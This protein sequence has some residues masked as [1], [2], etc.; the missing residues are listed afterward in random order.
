MCGKRVIISMVAVM[1]CL[2]ISMSVFAA[3]T[4][5]IAQMKVTVDKIIEILR[6]NELSEDAVLEKVGDLVRKKFDF[7]AM[8]QR[9]LG[10]YWKKGTE[11]QQDRFVE[12]FSQLLEDT[13]RGRIQAYTYSDEYV[14]Y[15]DERI[16]G[17]R[18]E[19]KTLVVAD[20]EI[21]VNYRMRL[22]GDD[23]LVYDV[24]IE[25]VSLVS[26]Y[27]NTYG[28]IIQKN[29]FDALL[30]QMEEKIRQLKEN[31][32]AGAEPETKTGQSKPQQSNGQQ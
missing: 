26:N 6:N 2:L 28:Q 14:K 29:G 27:R 9:T 4:S 5:P 22:K 3:T 10:V 24:I 30:S 31:P 21:P 12:L 1:G 18:A 25:D 17:T 23:W 8:A 13:Y 7:R 15:L 11:K 16:L 19:V 32:N 20:R